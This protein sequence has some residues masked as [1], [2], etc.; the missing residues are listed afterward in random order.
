MFVDISQSCNIIMSD[1]GLYWLVKYQFLSHAGLACF[2]N[3]I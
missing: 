2:K 1:V 3:V